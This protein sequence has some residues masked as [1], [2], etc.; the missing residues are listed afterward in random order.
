MALGPV[1]HPVAFAIWEHKAVLIRTPVGLCL[2]VPLE[3]N[4]LPTMKGPNSP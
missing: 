2:T 1:N 4:S 3:L